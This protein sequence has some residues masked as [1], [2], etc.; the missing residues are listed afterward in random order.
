[1]EN[2][3]W[4]E[5]T[6]LHYFV[7]K[8]QSTPKAELEIEDKE[9]LIDFIKAEKSHNVTVPLTLGGWTE[10]VYFNLLVASGSNQKAFAQNIA[11]TLAKYGFDGIDLDCKYPNT[12]GQDGN[13]IS[14]DDSENFLKFLQFLRAEVVPQSQISLAVPVHGFVGLDCEDLKDHKPYTKVSDFIA[15]MAYDLSSPSR[16]P[17]G[18]QMHHSL[19]LSMTLR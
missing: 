19:I 3:H 12:P 4:E 14:K 16:T 9:K 6:H 5:Y 18:F 10:S 2:I 15:I 7:V 13:Q 8:S 11:K 1:M 17:I